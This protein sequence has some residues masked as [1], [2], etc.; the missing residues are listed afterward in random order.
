VWLDFPQ[1]ASAS[2]MRWCCCGSIAI[3]SI[4]PVSHVDINT[5]CGVRIY[6]GL[7]T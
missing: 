4:C 2:V 3:I 1:T 5:V 6:M 7:V